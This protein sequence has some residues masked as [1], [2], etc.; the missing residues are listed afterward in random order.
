MI[1]Q[2][3]DVFDGFPVTVGCCSHFFDSGGGRPT[4]LRTF[5]L[6]ARGCLITARPGRG[7]GVAGL[8]LLLLHTAA[9]NSS[10]KSFDKLGFPARRPRKLIMLISHRN[11][12]G[13]SFER[14]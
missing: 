7:C 10:N 3:L 2:V 14:K 1:N 9:C 11:V 6:L 5:S 12:G 13:T 8:L 4:D